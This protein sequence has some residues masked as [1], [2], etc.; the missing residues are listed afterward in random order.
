MARRIDRR[1]LLLGALSAGGV[2]LAGR[3]VMEPAREGDIERTWS[4]IERWMSMN[5]PEALR[6]LRPGASEARVRAAEKRLALTVP[7]AFRRSLARHDGQEW[8]PAL[9]EFG[10][11]MSLEEI[12]TSSRD[13]ERYGIDEAASADEAWWRRGWL[14]FVARD[15]DYLSLARGPRGQGEV[16]C[17]LH[18]NEPVH[19]IVAPDFTTWLKRW[20][21]ELEAGVFEW[22]D[23]P[24][25]G[26]A[27]RE[28]RTSRLWPA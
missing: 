6:V 1:T 5:A 14:P 22:D 21:A 24:G 11:L 25:G 17:F 4:R 7:E 28:G 15:G 8:G 13:N 3:A 10:S 18:D 2:V 23:A 9:I 12:V 27:A 19:S 20:A 16:W 26:L